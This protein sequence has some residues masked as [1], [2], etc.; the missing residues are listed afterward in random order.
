LGR[1][2]YYN[3]N[4]TDWLE[5]LTEPGQRLRAE[6][7]LNQLDRLKPLRREARKAMIE[8]A[9]RHSAFKIVSAMPAL[10]PVRVAQIIAAVGSPFRFRTKRQFWTYCGFAV[11]TRSSA[12]YQIIGGKMERV[13]KN[14]QTRGLNPNFNHRLKVVF[15]S[16]ALE[17]LK[18]ETIRKIYDRL[19]AKGIKPEMARLTIARKLAAV[20]LAVWKKGEEYDSEKLTKI[21]E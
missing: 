15:K 4:R 2:V 18:D 5:K 19:M 20:T 21:T 9:R 6:F 11:V 10:G 3:R 12:D 17:A 7:L 13:N 16:A 1:D 14:V 8:E